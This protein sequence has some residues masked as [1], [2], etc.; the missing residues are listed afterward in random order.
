[1]TKPTKPSKPRKPKQEFV[2]FINSR[3]TGFGPGI[4]CVNTDEIFGDPTQAFAALPLH[5][6]PNG[7]KPMSGIPLMQFE[8]KAEKFHD[9]LE[10]I[11]GIWVMSPPVREFFE[12]LDAGAFAFRECRTQYPDGSPAPPRSLAVVTRIIDA[13]DRERSDFKINYHDPKWE[14]A[15]VFESNKNYFRE[16]AIGNCHF[17]MPAKATSHIV[18]SQLVKDEFKKRGWRGAEFKKAFLS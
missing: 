3:W 12:K 4:D 5:I 9:D 17:F 10:I 11:G 13:F 16:S 18:V 6:S 8:G 14:N 15:L 1:V 7:F 2:Y